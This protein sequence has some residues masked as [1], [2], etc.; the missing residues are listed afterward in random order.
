MDFVCTDET[1]TIS[2][3]C[4]SESVQ[5]IQICKLSEPHYGILGVSAL[6][7]DGGTCSPLPPAPHHLAFIGDSITCGYG[8]DA[9]SPEDAFSIATEHAAKSYAAQTAKLL[10][11]DAHILSYSGF[12]VYSGFPE[13]SCKNETDLLPLVY[14]AAGFYHYQ[15]ENW[16]S[17]ILLPFAPP[18]AVILYLGTNDSAYLHLFPEEGTAFQ[19][20]YTAFLQKLRSE[21]PTAF[22]VCML[23]MSSD[24][25]AA[26]FVTLLQL[27]N[28]K[29]TALLSAMCVP[30]LERIS[31]QIITPVRP[32]S[33]M[34]RNCSLI[35]CGNTCPSKSGQ[36]VFFRE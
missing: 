23:G 33:E 31:E 15:P 10:H 22:L 3:P 11:A 26:P 28:S 14:E 19:A 7:C 16:K 29:I 2:I 6:I 4:P 20:A 1:K 17:T 8:I 35:C 34:L 9:A 24:L 36:L 12:G 5:Q 32:H 30:Q 21:F 13:E 27:L 18:E 25:D